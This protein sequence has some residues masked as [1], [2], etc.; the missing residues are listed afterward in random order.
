M[1]LIFWVDKNTF[2]NGLLEKVFK[3]ASMPFYTQTSVKD[4]RYLVED[5]KPALIVLESTTFLDHAEAFKEQYLS[6]TLMQMTPFVLI[7]PIPSMEFIKHQ[8]GRLEKPLA[9]F[10]IPHKLKNI[11]TVN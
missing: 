10:E 6:S 8:L 5:L 11:L 1:G 2:S 7:D 3:T 9:P 4:I